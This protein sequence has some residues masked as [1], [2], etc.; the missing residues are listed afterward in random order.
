MNK[1][2]KQIKALENA[3]RKQADP[4]KRQ[5]IIEKIREMKEKKRLADFLAQ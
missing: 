2:E 3:A 4:V 1:H 5:R